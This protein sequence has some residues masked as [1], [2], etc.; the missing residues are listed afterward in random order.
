MDAPLIPEQR[1]DLIVG[2]LR[3]ESV[4]SY[5]QLAALLEVSHMTVRRDIAE[6]EKQGRVEATRKRY[7]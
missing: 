2:H 3:R 4:L 1:R 5:R 6:L 7:E